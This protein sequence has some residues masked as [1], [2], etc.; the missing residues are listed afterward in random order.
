MQ[1]TICSPLA[2]ALAANSNDANFV[3][4]KIPTI[5]EPG[6]I[7]IGQENGGYVPQ[8]MLI[9]PI[10]LGADND[11]F[12]VRIIG[13]RR[14]GSGNAPNVLWVPT[15]LGEFACTCCATVGIAGAP[16]IA[17]ERFCDTI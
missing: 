9:V 7:K 6:G 3:A 14:I 8:C 4:T 13:W 1:T 10:G 16:V 12:S 5:T 15:C 2:R 11:V 17:T